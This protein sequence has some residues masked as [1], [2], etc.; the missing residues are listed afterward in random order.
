MIG[1]QALRVV[2]QVYLSTADEFAHDIRDAGDDLDVID[3]LMRRKIA[4]IHKRNA[5]LEAM[6]E[7]AC[8]Q[9]CESES[10]EP[11]G[12]EAQVRA[13]PE[14]LAQ[15]EELKPLAQL[16]WSWTPVSKRLRSRLLTWP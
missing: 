11:S 15:T 4:S 14:R 13:K 6:L 8:H 16:E 12:D 1:R 2:Y 7:K 3:I 9:Q 5:S 10:T